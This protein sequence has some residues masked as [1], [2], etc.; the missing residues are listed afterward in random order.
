M[1]LGSNWKQTLDQSDF[2]FFN[3]RGIKERCQSHQGE[4]MFPTEKHVHKPGGFLYNNCSPL[5]SAAVLMET[6]QDDCF[7]PEWFQK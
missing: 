1:D 5:A 3:A 4:T 2:I 6:T 7:S